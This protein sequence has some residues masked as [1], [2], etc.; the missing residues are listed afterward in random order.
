[1]KHSYL[2][3]IIF[4]LISTNTAAQ[5]LHTSFTA[6]IT[7]NKDPELSKNFPKFK[8]LFD[9]NEDGK[10]DPV[11]D[12]VLQTEHVRDYPKFKTH[13]LG[14]FLFPNMKYSYDEM[15]Y[16]NF[17]FNEKP[18][19]AGNTFN[20]HFL[21]SNSRNPIVINRN[22]NGYYF[23]LKNE[24]EWKAL[25]A[26]IK[27]IWPAFSTDPYP[28]N[29]THNSY[30]TDFYFAP[31]KGLIDSYGGDGDGSTG[32]SLSFA[33][34]T[35]IALNEFKAAENNGLNMSEWNKRIPLSYPD[36][37]NICSDIKKVSCTTFPYT[38]YYATKEQR[39]YFP[40]FFGQAANSLVYEKNNQSNWILRYNFNMDFERD[41]PKP[42]K[43]LKDKLGKIKETTNI[44]LFLDTDPVSKDP[45]FF[46]WMKLGRD[47]EVYY[48]SNSLIKK[49]TI[50]H[51]PPS[52]ATNIL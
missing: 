30:P 34:N 43:I 49:V 10:F 46:N 14:D 28:G 5:Q 21:F 2:S 11:E 9:L 40:P 45:A 37:N 27:D 29:V 36:T 16:L 1:V 17:N 52:A 33:P 15:M 18:A 23:S 7:F 13:G 8:V 50:E 26:A 35:Y 19:K 42:Y 12:L 51:R 6:E 47:Q 4:T 32:V 24:L 25:L 39:Q 20:S 22:S 48:P 44:K 41:L 31:T 38:M 3:A